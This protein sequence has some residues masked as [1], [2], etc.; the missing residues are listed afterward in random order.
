MSGYENTQKKS[1]RRNDPEYLIRKA[2]KLKQQTHNL[3]ILNDI[4]NYLDDVIKANPEV[5]MIDGKIIDTKVKMS[6]VIEYLSS[7]NYSIEDTKVISQ[8]NYI[9]VELANARMNH[10]ISG[11]R[12][13]IR[14]LYLEER[15]K[16][17]YKKELHGKIDQII[18][19]H[20][21]LFYWD[22][23]S[24]GENYDVELK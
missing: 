4:A 11:D 24:T 17:S 10:L 3:D 2:E 5:V 1:F 23:E 20:Q 19:T 15:L 9:M 18:K 22:E 7:K 6:D 21:N 8:M 16:T 12:V 14:V 13:N